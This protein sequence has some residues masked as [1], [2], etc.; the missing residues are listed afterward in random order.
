MDAR[1]HLQDG[2]QGPCFSAA[3]PFA[4]GWGS[5]ECYST[6]APPDSVWQVVVMTK[7]SEEDYAE[8]LGAEMPLDKMQHIKVTTQ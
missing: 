6:L 3:P 1:V 5:I 7:F 4:L 8:F 2:K